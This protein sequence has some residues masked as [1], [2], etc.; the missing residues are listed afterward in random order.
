MSIFILFE[1][2][3]KLLEIWF[4]KNMSIFILF[5]NEQ[6]LLEIWFTMKTGRYLFC[7]KMS[8]HSLKYDLQWKQ[9][10]IYFVWKW[11]DTPWNMIY[12][13]KWLKL[14]LKKEA[15]WFNNIKKLWFYA[16]QI[17]ILTRKW[18]AQKSK[19]IKI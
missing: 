18:C 17:I 9:V 19:N 15:F 12:K 14:S 1:N 7:M 10:D 5:E 13:E 6:T 2:E 4:T 8:R 16:F 11:A 3:Q